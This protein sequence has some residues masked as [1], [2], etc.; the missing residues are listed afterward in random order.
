MIIDCHVHL[1]RQ[2]GEAMETK[3]AEML[4]CMDRLSLDRVCV[5][6]GGMLIAHPTAADLIE[7]NAYVA[8][9]AA[10][11]PDRITGFVY[12]SPNHPELAV[13]HIAQYAALGFGGVK[14]WVCRLADHCGND[15]VCEQAQRFGLP[16]L[17]HTWTKTGGNMETESEPKH[18]VPLA[19]RHPQVNFIM[20]HSGGD[21]ERGLRT[22]ADIPNISP[23]TC[24][25]D[26][27]AGFV[28]LAVSLC[29][30]D[31]VLYGSDATGRSFAS[32]LSK[33][34]GADISDADKALILSGNL[35]RMMPHDH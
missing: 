24:G 30:A 26:P 10:A 18:L 19:L 8:A 14:L 20:A 16:V 32:Q 33:V 1:Y 27:E 23:D 3:I 11:A 6:M 34:T 25:F 15:P 17:S 12:T 9:A 2:P 29:G 13:E 7:A 5:S 31:R 4:A 28:E 22:V 35:L 21:W